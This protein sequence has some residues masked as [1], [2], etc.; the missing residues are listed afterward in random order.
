MEKLFTIQ[1][2]TIISVL[3]IILL[4]KTSM[5]TAELLI[6]A[7]SLLVIFFMLFNMNKPGFWTLAAVLLVMH[8]FNVAY[9]YMLIGKDFFLYVI[10][11]LDMIGIALFF[12]GSKKRKVLADA[13]V[14]RPKSYE[15]E[16]EVKE[17]TKEEPAVVEYPD[18]KYV[19]SENGKSY[20]SLD[21]AWADN[22]KEENKIWFETRSAAENAGLEPHSCL[23][24]YRPGKYV[25][26]ENGKSYH[27]AKCRFAKRIKKK[28]RIWFKTRR[29]AESEGYEPHDCA[30]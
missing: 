13:R 25:A 4:L 17:L 9:L 10:A 16:K 12:I 23:V 28:N 11:I 3:E 2:L 20:H 7:V 30:E 14:M 18:K 6:I 27:T 22:I 19:A 24:D 21:C 26:S 8:M 1:L 5:V 15:I 29:K